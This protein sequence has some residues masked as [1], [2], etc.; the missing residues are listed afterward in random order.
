[1]CIILTGPSGVGKTTISRFLAETLNYKHIRL[2]SFQNDIKYQGEMNNMGINTSSQIGYAYI[3]RKAIE[4]YGEGKYILD[5]GSV[6]SYFEKSSPFEDVKNLLS[7]YENV[8]RLIPSYDIKEWEG[9]LAN[10]KGITRSNGSYMGFKK[11]LETYLSDEYEAIPT[12]KVVCTNNLSIEQ[13]GVAII[14]L[15]KTE[16]PNKLE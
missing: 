1:M 13:C 11:Q 5:F 12:N 7:S 6:H 16:F 2:D 4:N 3:V 9:I 15:C 14:K 8:I 10:Q